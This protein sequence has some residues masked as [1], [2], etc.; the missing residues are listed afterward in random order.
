M[1][2]A[3][4]STYIPLKYA[5]QNIIQGQVVEDRREAQAVLRKLRA[6]AGGFSS[7]D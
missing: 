1:A 3:P 5:A 6:W 2:H 7:W 4:V